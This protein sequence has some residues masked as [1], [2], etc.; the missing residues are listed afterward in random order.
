MALEAGMRVLRHEDG[1]VRPATVLEVLDG[2]DGQC[3]LIAYDEGGQG[4]W[5]AE[6][7]EVEG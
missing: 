7:L 6:S 5:R 1:E 3:C 4:W 2:P